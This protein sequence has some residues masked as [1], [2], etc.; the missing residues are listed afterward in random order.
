MM[1]SYQTTGSENELTIRISTYSPSR[2]HSSAGRCS[3]SG[4]LKR[5][6]SL[7]CMPLFQED[8]ATCPYR[9]IATIDL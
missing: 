3:P 9:R 6:V 4:T 1:N 7:I 8:A 2:F 5:R